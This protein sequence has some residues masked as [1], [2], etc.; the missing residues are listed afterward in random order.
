MTHEVREFRFHKH[1]V[2]LVAEFVVAV[3]RPVHEA[4]P[5]PEERVTD[6]IPA[7]FAPF[8]SFRDRDVLVD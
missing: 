2:G 4:E 8:F 6:P 7:P 5:E 1:L 3:T